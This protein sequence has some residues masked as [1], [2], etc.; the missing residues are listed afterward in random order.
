PRVFKIVGREV[1]QVCSSRQRNLRV[2]QR[3]PVEAVSI[4]HGVVNCINWSASLEHRGVR[5]IDRFGIEIWQVAEGIAIYIEFF[6]AVRSR[7]LCGTALDSL[8][9]GYLADT[10]S[11]I[12]I[13][14]VEICDVT[15][16]IIEKRA[17]QR[18]GICDIG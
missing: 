14:R 3:P 11:G 5:R 13:R 17:F 1:V 18:S 12:P 2:L 6:A 7:N 15:T 8:T 9:T 4:S 10:E 16:G